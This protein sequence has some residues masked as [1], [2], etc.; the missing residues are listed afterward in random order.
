M[1]F[2]ASKYSWT[3]ERMSCVAGW[4]AATCICAPSRRCYGRIAGDDYIPDY[5]VTRRG[6]G[7][8]G[9]SAADNAAERLGRDVLTVLDALK[10]NKPVL[11]GHS[12]AG[13]ELS[14][15]AST[16]PRRVAGLVYLEA[17]Y[18]YAFDNGTGP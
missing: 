10:L 5:G 2:Q 1:P 16:Q 17:G 4:T 18:P 14:F 6:F 15:V 9:F 11:V 7:E 12:I 8:S 3:N 13:A